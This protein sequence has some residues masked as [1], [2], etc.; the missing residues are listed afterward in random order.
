[1]PQEEVGLRAVIDN[2]SGFMASANQIQRAY[3]DLGTATDT[4][5]KRTSALGDVM[6]TAVG[7][8]VGQ[9]AY[10]AVGAVTGSIKEAIG[11][12]ATFEQQINILG[13]AARSSGTGLGTLSEAALKVGADTRLVGI[14]ATQTADAV[15]GLYKAGLKTSD[16]FGDLNGYMKGNIELGGALRA[17]VD[18]QAAS[19]LNLAYAS[20][21]VAVAMATYGLK[22]T[23]ANRITNSFV[24]A[25]DASVASVGDLVEAMRTIGPTAAQFGLTLEETNTLL[26]ILSTRGIKG[27]EAGTALRSMFTNLMRPTKEVKEALA[28]LGV[29]LYDTQGNL[30]APVEM[31]KAFSDA[32]YGTSQ[33]TTEVG[34][35]TKEQTAKIKEYTTALNTAKK[36]LAE[37]AAGIRG[38]GQTEKVRAKAIDELNKKVAYYTGQIKAVNVAQTKTVVS[39]RKLTEEQRNQYIQT[40]A[41][42]Y[43]MKA[44]ASLLEEGPEGYQKMEKAI[45]EAATAQEVMAART[46]GLQAALEVLRG[47][48]ETLMIKAATPFI[49]KFLTPAIRGL[50]EFLSGLAELD[51]TPI[52]IAFT[53]WKDRGLELIGVLD[54]V[55][56]EDIRK[57]IDP[58]RA[59]IAEFN[60]EIDRIRKMNLEGLLYGLYKALDTVFSSDLAIRIASVVGTIIKKVQELHDIIY[61]PPGGITLSDRI[62]FQLWKVW[63]LWEDFHSKLEEK[64]RVSWRGIKAVYGFGDLDL[65]KWMEEKLAPLRKA[66]DEHHDA[67]FAKAKEVW[68]DKVWP[69]L[70]KVGTKIVEL[71]EKVDEHLPQMQTVI[72]I[73][74]LAIG[75]AI[76]YNILGPVGLIVTAVK[77]L[78]K[79]WDEDWGGI[80]E[81]T[82]EATDKIRPKIMLIIVRVE[83]LY[84]AVRMK[85]GQIK[86][87]LLI[88]GID[89][90]GWRKDVGGSIEDLRLKYIE[91]LR[92]AWD[93]AMG[94]MERA[95]LDFW[96]GFSPTIEP[97]QK[98]FNWWVSENLLPRIR[99]LSKE[100]SDLYAD[101][102]KPAI[103]GVTVAISEFLKK[104]PG[105]V[106]FLDKMIE[107]VGKLAGGTMLGLLAYI[108]GIVELALLALTKA[109]ETAGRAIDGIVFIIQAGFWVWDKILS[110]ITSTTDALKRLWQWTQDH[111][112]NIRINF[113][114]P[115]S[116]LI[117]MMENWGKFPWD[118]TSGGRGGTQGGAQGY[119]GAG[120]TG[121]GRMVTAPAI[122]GGS[123][124]SRQTTNTW[125]PVINANYAQT[126]SPVSIRHDL[127]ALAMLYR[128]R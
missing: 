126:Q 92:K 71:R 61:A 63:F 100:I 1:M 74:A 44:F 13:V 20:E 52:T 29:E 62:E 108:L 76:L 118:W 90:E 75:G 7:F 46:K 3:G 73:V 95:W 99:D 30:K 82:T 119:A 27:S 78:R 125:S 4:V 115:P 12:A 32:L 123:S 96:R 83:D 53:A 97:T 45:L 89:W 18:L 124:Y 93:K 109:L 19:E 22:A 80:Q 101:H 98:F 50:A 120:M 66:W 70:D 41:G 94:V 39:T 65:G 31:I 68:T 54:R 84:D 35:A 107:L 5:T 16:I 26:A 34:G 105:V 28:E 25:A 104:H 8:A 72:E 102:L 87:E 49:Q 24:K 57:K 106:L 21:A 60:E 128:M 10:K 6:K 121:Y 42:T 112:I 114:S 103:D 36:G 116:W 88:A 85:F 55:F 33:V 58:V 47:A 59:K 86:T 51:L 37:Y 15:T 111:T 38:A 69:A 48:I 77:V 113:P 40:L 64:T 91:P 14:T 56:G 122:A 117:W 67:I 23:E 9:V 2:M 43:G 79:A 110:S 127:E 17:A 81:K 11:T